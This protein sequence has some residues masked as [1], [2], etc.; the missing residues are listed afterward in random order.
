MK[1]L[2]TFEEFI[3]ENINEADMTKFYDGFVLYDIKKGKEYK[4]RYI[5][6]IKNN[7]LE[8]EIIKKIA[9]ETISREESIG[10]NRFIKKGEWDKSELDV[11]EVKR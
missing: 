6:G 8:D 4:S 7:V 3:N 5:K 2:H 1:N 9:K 10:V 11:E